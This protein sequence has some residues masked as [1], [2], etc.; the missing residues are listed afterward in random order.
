[1]ENCLLVAVNSLNFT[2]AERDQIINNAVNK[3]LQKST[4]YLCQKN[5]IKDAVFYLI[6]MI[7]MKK[8]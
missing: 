6:A 5:K 8:I 3:Y 2:S 7:V 1:M 4:S